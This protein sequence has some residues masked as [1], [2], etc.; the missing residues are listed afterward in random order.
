[1]SLPVSSVSPATN[2]FSTNKA[3]ASD[4]S[5]PAGNAILAGAPFGTGGVWSENE[6]AIRHLPR[7]TSPGAL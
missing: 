1:M 5:H 4:P 6:K 2:E 7:D 3:R